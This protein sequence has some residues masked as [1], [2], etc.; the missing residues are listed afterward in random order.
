MLARLGGVLILAAI[1]ALGVAVLVGL[2]GDAMSVPDRSPGGLV[3]AA[4]LIAL[5]GG[6]V[7][8][9]IAGPVPLDG[10]VLRGALT[11]TGI[12]LVVVTLAAPATM[13][14]EWV[15][16]LLVGGALAWIG[17]IVLI[18]TLLARSGLPRRIGALA[19]GGIVLAAI[20]QSLIA[21]N[22]GGAMLPAPIGWAVILAGLGALIAAL[23]GLAAIG[24][25]R[26][27]PGPAP[28]TAADPT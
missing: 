16:A 4:G 11:A 24:L 15:Y 27:G 22:G 9:G 3:M 10:R 18:I 17:A 12:G 13:D 5:G 25:A 1:A 26:L 23:L 14:S 20:G 8:L 7:A 2:T 19:I 28:I 6:F 21:D